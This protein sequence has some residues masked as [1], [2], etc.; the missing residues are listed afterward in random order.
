MSENESLKKINAIAQNGDIES[1]F[2]L[3]RYYSDPRYR[4]DEEA[5]KWFKMAADQGHQTSQMY[6]GY[7]YDICEGVKFNAKNALEYYKMATLQYFLSGFFEYGQGKGRKVFEVDP[8]LFRKTVS[9]DVSNTSYQAAMKYFGTSFL[10]L[11][12]PII[13][14]ESKY[15]EFKKIF[16]DAIKKL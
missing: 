15:K 8:N 16:D 14:I 9:T 2:Y 6:V 1:Q 10:P 13:N 3:G 12:L 7:S 4:N 11:E 5:F